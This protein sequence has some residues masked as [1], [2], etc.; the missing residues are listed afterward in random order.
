MHGVSFGVYVAAS[1][2]TSLT[3][4]DNVAD[5]LD[6]RE[7][8]GHGGYLLNRRVLGHF[9]QLNSVSLPNGGEIA[10]NQMIN[11]DGIASVEDILSFYQSHGSAENAVLVHDNYLQGAIVA[12]QTT[13]DTGGGS[14]GWCFQ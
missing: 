6:D 7:S 10:W 4:K 14:N 2:A 13:P 12:G 5:N 8:D 9:I 11:S 3:I 1:T